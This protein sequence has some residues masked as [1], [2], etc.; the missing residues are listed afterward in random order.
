M[1]GC[2]LSQLLIAFLPLADFHYP[3][4]L[5]APPYSLSCRKINPKEL[6]LLVDL[7]AQSFRVLR[8]LIFAS[9]AQFGMKRD[10]FGIVRPS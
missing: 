2:L 1:A 5:S 10:S 3:C 7:D 4:A 8:E 9:S 6:S